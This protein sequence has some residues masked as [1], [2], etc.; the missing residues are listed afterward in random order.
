MSSC[1]AT[2]KTATSTAST[3]TPT[4]VVKPTPSIAV[5]QTQ[6]MEREEKANLAKKKEM[7]KAAQKHVDMLSR[8]HK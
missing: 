7:K 3:T 2:I 8:I 5:T 1:L 4:G 6:S